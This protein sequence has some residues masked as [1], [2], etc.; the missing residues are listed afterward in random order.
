[1]E[2][3]TAAPRSLGG[4]SDGLA[5]APNWYSNMLAFCWRAY[6]WSTQGAKVS[7]YT[8]YENTDLSF[9]TL[10]QSPS[11]HLCN[12]RSARGHLLVTVTMNRHRVMLVMLVRSRTIA[13]AVVTVSATT[14]MHP[15]ASER[16]LSKMDLRGK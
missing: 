8:N 2:P 5:R 9:P 7:R 11:S 10:L 3:A 13:A 4:Q 1:M 12:I 6:T 14:V 16:I 15:D